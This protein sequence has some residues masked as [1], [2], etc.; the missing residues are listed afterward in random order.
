Q[1][2]VLGLVGGLRRLR[3]L[4]LGGQLVV[5][6]LPVGPGRVV[7]NPEGPDNQAEHQVEEDQDLADDCHDPFPLACWRSLA[8]GPGP[9]EPGP[10]CARRFIPPR[11]L[12]SSG[13][14]ICAARFPVSSA[15]SPAPAGAPSPSDSS[16]GVKPPPPCASC[17]GT[18]SAPSRAP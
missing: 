2:L 9:P 8:A 16:G 15:L 5:A 6:V 17:A 4:E 14:G 3:H 18:R 13:A 10:R 12:P 11:Y 1:L 7:Q